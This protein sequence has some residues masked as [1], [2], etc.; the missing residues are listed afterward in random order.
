[1]KIN[2][3]FSSGFTFIEM[4]VTVAIMMVILGGGIAAFINF[5]DKQ[6]VTTSAKELQTYLR[7]AQ[8]K[9][10][11]GDRPEVCTKLISYAVRATTAPGSEVQLIAI[12]ESQE[13]QRNSYFLPNSLN[14]EADLDISFLGLSGGVVGEGEI[15]IRSDNRIYSFTVTKGGEIQEGSLVDN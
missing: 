10:R 8:I 11:V 6:V 3:K 9:A 2:L 7:S 14:L 5:N 1:M 15:R 4:L 13:V 12:C